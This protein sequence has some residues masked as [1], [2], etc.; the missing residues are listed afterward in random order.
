M[1]PVSG[2]SSNKRSRKD[3]HGPAEGPESQRY[4]PARQKTRYVA[5]MAQLNSAQPVSIGKNYMFHSLCS[6][7]CAR[8]FVF[9]SAPLCETVSVCIDLCVRACVDLYVL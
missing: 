3:L 4:L 1:F 5:Q 9:S 7:T 6:W 8:I 2:N